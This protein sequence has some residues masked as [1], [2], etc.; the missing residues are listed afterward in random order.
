MASPSD[1]AVSTAF[2]VLWLR[3]SC[4]LETLGSLEG[5]FLFT[6]GP[7]YSLSACSPRTEVIDCVFL[8][9]HLRR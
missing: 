3:V 2:P 9:I 1:L 8:A 4:P 5:L 6:R 7:S